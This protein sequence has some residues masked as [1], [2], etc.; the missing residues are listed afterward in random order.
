[1][2][3]RE[4][5]V[6]YVP[7]DSLLFPHLTVRQNIE[8]GAPGELDALARAAI[9]RLSIDALLQRGVSGLSGGERQRVALVR[10]LARRPRVLL[11]DEPLSALD[12]EM[13][14]AAMHLLSEVRD[15]AGVP[16]VYVTHDRDEALAVADHAI[17]LREGRVDAHGV[18]ADVL[19]Q[20]VGARRSAG[21]SPPAR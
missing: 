16:I 3:S 4:R 10:A 17:V 12:G 7:Q 6:G 5:H 8:Y 18:P 14:D 9:A 21:A 1:V 13:R 15:V 11:L 20:A 2:P 19:P